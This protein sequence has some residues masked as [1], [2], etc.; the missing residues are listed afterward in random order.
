MSVG[1]GPA[2]GGN[3]G[4]FAWPAFVRQP[5]R[6]CNKPLP[7]GERDEPHTTAPRTASS[8]RKITGRVTTS[9]SSDTW[10]ARPSSNRRFRRIARIKHAQRTNSP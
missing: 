9:G 1:S 5:A 7:R 10:L 8:N 4:R 2:V 3:A 6:P